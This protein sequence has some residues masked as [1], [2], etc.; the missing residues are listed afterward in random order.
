M[1]EVTLIIVIAGCVSGALL[2]TLLVY[3]VMRIR[4]HAKEI[5]LLQS[6]LG[7]TI[8][9]A[10]RDR[11]AFENSLQNG[12]NEASEMRGSFNAVT[13]VSPNMNL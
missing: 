4:T 11:V 10:R 13:G 12:D 1:S 9:A 6:Q 5:R 3:I 7:D 8:D 2:C